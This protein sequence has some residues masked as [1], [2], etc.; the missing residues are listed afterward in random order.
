MFPILNFF[1]REIGSYA[2][3][4]FLGFIVCGITICLSCKHLK[5][6][7]EDVAI[8]ELVVAGGLLFGGHL[9]YG[10]LDIPKIITL[11]NNALSV[12]LATT[13]SAL[14]TCFGGMV[15]YGGFLGGIASLSI[16]I[17]FSKAEFKHSLFDIYAFSI[18]LFHFFGR[19]G[20][21]FAGCCYGIEA[22]FG[23]TVNGN[24]LVPSI[25]GVK[26]FPVSLLE[27][28]LNLILFVIIFLL[29]RKSILKKRLLYLYM[30][31]YSAIRFFIE[32]LRG[33]EIRGFY[34]GVSTSQ[35][36]SIFLFL[37]GGILL[38]KNQYTKKRLLEQIK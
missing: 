24:T 7:V 15:F 37:I 32:F 17:H 3:F 23:F 27:A 38:I 9:L 22:S 5:I 36:I 2:I 12:P 13:L 8:M 26:R 29:F 28:I 30:I 1:G 25:N 33:D 19:I 34:F 10:L 21:F 20:C 18:P 35:W 16:Y 4:A 31:L 14:L 6:G 11:L